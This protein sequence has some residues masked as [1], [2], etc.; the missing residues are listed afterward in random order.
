[1]NFYID[2]DQ[3]S[4]L[5]PSVL[6]TLIIVEQLKLFLPKKIPTKLLTLIIALIISIVLPIYTC[7]KDQY[8]LLNNIFNGFIVSF[9]SMNGFD[10]LKSIWTRLTGEQDE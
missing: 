4:S 6:L 9:I 10:S 3:Y 7:P 2:F 1:M 8:N 5:A